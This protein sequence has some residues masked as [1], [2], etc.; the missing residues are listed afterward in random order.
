VLELAGS[1]T[2]CPV[3]PHFCSTKVVAL[4]RSGRH[5]N[6]LERR[7]IGLKSSCNGKAVGRWQAGRQ[8]ASQQLQERHGRIIQAGRGLP[9]RGLPPCQPAHPAC[10]AGHS[11]A[12]DMQAGQHNIAARACLHGA[13]CG[14]GLCVVWDHRRWHALQPR[15]VP[16]AGHARPRRLCC[17][18]P[19]CPHQGARQRLSHHLVP[20]VIGVRPAQHSTAGSAAGST[21]RGS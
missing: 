14:G 5:S 21:A 12:Q 9:N 6:P 18:L 20:P 8:A 16:P 15:V 19:H 7:T 13:D 3:H 10:P 17:R 11:A 4:G 2:A 1:P